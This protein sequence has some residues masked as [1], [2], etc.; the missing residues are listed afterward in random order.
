MQA[1]SRL[2]RLAVLAARDAGNSTREFAEKYGVSQ[3]GVR[4]VSP[5][6]RLHR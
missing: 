1:Y 5:P 2:K 3:S 4:R 6:A